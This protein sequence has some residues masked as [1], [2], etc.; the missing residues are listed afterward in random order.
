MKLFWANDENCGEQTAKVSG[1]EMPYQ[2]VQ[3]SLQ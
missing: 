1:R 3:P 2:D